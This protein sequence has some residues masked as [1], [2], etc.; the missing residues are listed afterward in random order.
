MSDPNRVIVTTEDYPF[1]LVHA[2]SVHN[3]DFPEVRG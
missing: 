1:H 2:L 3:R